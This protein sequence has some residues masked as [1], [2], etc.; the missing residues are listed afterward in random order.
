MQASRFWS[1]RLARNDRAAACD[2]LTLRLA[3]RSPVSECRLN[4][5][6]CT[7][8]SHLLTQLARNT[9]S[10]H[11]LNRDARVTKSTE[12]RHSAITPVR[13]LN[14][15]DCVLTLQVASQSQ[16]QAKEVAASEH[17]SHMC[18][19]SRGGRVSR[20]HL[21]LEVGAAWCQSAVVPRH[22]RLS[23]QRRH[24][25]PLVQ[26]QLL[27][28]RRHLHRGTSVR[29]QRGTST[30]RYECR[31]VRVLTGTSAERYMYVYRDVRVQSDTSKG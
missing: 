28:G 22:A 15:V 23:R 13:P 7:V 11:R 19:D 16:L 12:S 26:R 25:R 4:D 1:A 30:E 31:E 27:L 29:V 20:A 24:Q 3:P 14:D 6:G 8:L 17:G 9:T 2:T 21:S 10:P 5:G 18:L